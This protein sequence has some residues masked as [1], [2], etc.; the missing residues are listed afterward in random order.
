MVFRQS[1]PEEIIE[2]YT[3]SIMYDFDM[4]KFDAY[5]YPINGGENPRKVHYVEDIEGRIL[6]LNIGP[7]VDRAPWSLWHDMDARK[8]KPI[9]GNKQW[10]SKLWCLINLGF[11]FENGFMR[12]NRGSAK[13]LQEDLGYTNYICKN[14]LF[15]MK[16]KEVENAYELTVR[17]HSEDRPCSCIRLSYSQFMKELRDVKGLEDM[18]ELVRETYDSLKDGNNVKQ[19]LTC[20]EELIAKDKA[21]YETYNI[22]L[23]LINALEQ[24]LNKPKVRN[25]IERYRYPSTFEDEPEEKILTDEERI[26]ELYLELCNVEAGGERIAG[27]CLNNAER[28]REAVKRLKLNLVCDWELDVTPRDILAYLIE[29]KDENPKSFGNFRDKKDSRDDW[30]FL[31]DCYKYFF[32]KSKVKKMR[33]RYKET[34]GVSGTADALYWLEKFVN[35]PDF[36]PSEL[37][38]I[39]F[40]LPKSEVE[41]T[42]PEREEEPEELDAIVLVADSESV[43]EEWY[44]YAESRL[45][46]FIFYTDDLREWFNKHVV[47]E[48]MASGEWPARAKG[49]ELVDILEDV[50]DSLQ[51]GRF[52]RVFANRRAFEKEYEAQCELVEDLNEQASS[53]AKELGSL[54]MKLS[55]LSEKK[56]EEKKMKLEELGAVFNRLSLSVVYKTILELWSEHAEGGALKEFTDSYIANTV[57]FIFNES[58]SLDEAISKLKE[59][60][61]SLKGITIRP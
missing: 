56:R 7:V 6:A 37:R 3:A 2:G 14:V 27:K 50:N 43:K 44:E 47:K 40:A 4:K 15:N 17:E 25:Y 57:A 36:A 61:E 22:E 24:F 59:H 18:F 52:Y 54:N 21:R 9:S 19:S 60:A 20:D 32:G 23:K 51:S 8:Y 12:V 13:D 26:E 11:D 53:C 33:D 55:S 38:G 45:E 31:S 34:Y 1:V 29:L 41:Y 35:E 48:R 10:A 58:E 46:K 42:L 30:K 16:N 28:A 49:E 39:A 5:V